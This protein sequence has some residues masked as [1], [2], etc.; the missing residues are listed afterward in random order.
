MGMSHVSSAWRRLQPDGELNGWSALHFGNVRA[1]SRAVHWR[2]FV[3]MGVPM[4]GAAGAA[5]HPGCSLS[6]AGHIDCCGGSPRRPL[7]GAVASEGGRGTV[8]M[9]SRMCTR[10]S[11]LGSIWG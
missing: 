2:K 4:Y 11:C 5:A 3:A 6:R 9:C 10:K 7:N 1:R 8:G